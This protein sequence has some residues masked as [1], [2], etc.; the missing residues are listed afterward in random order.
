VFRRD[1]PSIAQGRY[2][3]FCQC[4]IDIIG[5]FDNPILQDVEILKITSE[6]YRKFN[7]RFTIRLNHIRLLELCLLNYGILPE[8]LR[9]V[10]NIIDE[11]DKN[12]WEYIE[13][14]LRNNDITDENIIN[15]I[16]QCSVLRGSPLE[17]LINLRNTYSEN[18]EILLIINELEILFTYCKIYDC[19][20]DITMDLFL[21][22]GLDY[23]TGIIFEIICTDNNTIGSIG[24]G[25]SGNK[26]P[27]IGVC[28]GIER[29][30]TII[31]QTKE[32]D[33]N[34]LL[35]VD[36]YCS[37]AIINKKHESELNQQM[38]NY[39]MSILNIIWQADISA[40]LCE[41]ISKPIKE[42]ILESVKKCCKKIIIIGENELN[43]CSVSIKTI[44]TKN[45]ITVSKNDFISYLR[46]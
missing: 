32:R 3:E 44:E 9:C 27:A 43:T 7:F 12:S 26:I 19:L 4:D 24:G 8:K 21:A 42:Q 10:I 20:D 37:V 23:Y 29:I 14:K 45:Q 39:A 18:Q 34:Q 25:F 38:L 5:H 15:N 1:D 40:E 22:R 41:N 2:R 6:I 33:K 17:F 31:K 13:N 36:L 28:I 16:R 46:E 30:L 35:A 11:F